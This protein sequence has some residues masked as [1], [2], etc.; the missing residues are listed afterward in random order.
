MRAET[1]QGR[2]EAVWRDRAHRL[3][4]RSAATEVGQDLRPVMV[5]GIGAERYAVELR[6]VEEVLPQV[7]VTPV[8]GAAAVVA[9]VINVHGDIRPVMDL[10]RLL[11]MD[12]VASGARPRVIVLCKEGRRMGL[13]IDSVE[14]I[15]WIGSQELESDE[16]SGRPRHI[17]GSTKDLLMLMN[18]E[19][20][21]AELQIGV[22]A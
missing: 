12:G 11:G 21:F 17:T 5:L 13:Q 15:R 6:D 7:R 22:A 14:Q 10:R 20:I 4:R 16:N 9:G 8:P 1:E 19:A 18:T 2:M 3:S